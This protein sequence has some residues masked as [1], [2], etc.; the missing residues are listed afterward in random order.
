VFAHRP[1][2]RPPVPRPGGGVYGGGVCQKPDISTLGQLRAAEYTPRN[3][4]Q[5]LR[6]NLLAALADGRDPGPG[7]HGFDHTGVPQLERAIIAGHDVV[8]LGERGQGK[9]RLL[10]TL[11]GL[12]D[13]WSP[14]VADSELNEDPFAPI[15]DAT[16]RRIAA[17]DDAL[18]I[19]WRHR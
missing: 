12:M 8:L 16:R 1:Q 5:E 14:V 7:R 11:T 15:T 3:L 18:A 4:R 17:E 13:E 6:E 9:T 19:T 10:R 2:R